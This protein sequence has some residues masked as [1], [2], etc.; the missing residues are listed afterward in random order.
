MEE[1]FPSSIVVPSD[2]FDVRKLCY[3]YT[4]YC[5]DVCSNPV[6]QEQCVVK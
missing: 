6:K 3:C 4:V 1:A 5:H 2:L